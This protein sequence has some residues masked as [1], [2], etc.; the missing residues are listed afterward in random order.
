[1]VT[2]QEWLVSYL[3]QALEQSSENGAKRLLQVYIETLYHV[4]LI[5]L[6]PVA[7]AVDLA[8]FAGCEFEC[9]CGF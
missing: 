6:W 3:G 7:M 1:M 2:L 5:W 4:M 8:V 9:E